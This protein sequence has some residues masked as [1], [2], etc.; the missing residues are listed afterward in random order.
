MA[1]CTSRI[2]CFTAIVNTLPIFKGKP[3][4]LLDLRRLRKLSD[5]ADLFSH[6]HNP[7][8]ETKIFTDP[9]YA[10]ER[11]HY[12]HF[13]NQ[14][15]I[16]IKKLARV[17]ASL[18]NET[19]NYFASQLEGLNAPKVLLTPEQAVQTGLNIAEKALEDVKITA[20]SKNT[21]DYL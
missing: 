13:E 20:D 9:E 3:D 5:T 12:L 18:S 4:L 2:L 7:A 8:L 10:K 19:E 16:T 21:K 17:L 15:N 11:D 14:V 1:S 6:P